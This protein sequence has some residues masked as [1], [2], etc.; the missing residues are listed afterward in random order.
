MKKKEVEKV[1]LF[2]LSEIPK[3]LAFEHKNII[4]DYIR[5]TFRK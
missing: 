5:F 3:K 4:K 2:D 1:K